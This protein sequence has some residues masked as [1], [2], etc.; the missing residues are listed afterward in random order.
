MKNKK[1]ISSI[2]ATPLLIILAIVA[3]VIIYPYI[4]TLISQELI[5]PKF[6]TG[7]PSSQIGTSC[8]NG[9]KETGEECD[10]M[11]LGEV[12]NCVDLEFVSGYLSCLQDCTFN[13]DECS[14]QAELSTY[15]CKSTYATPSHAPIRSGSCN[16]N[17]CYSGYSYMY[18]DYWTFAPNVSE[19]CS[20]VY[21]SACSLTPSCNESWST[22]LGCSFEEVGCTFPTTAVCGNSNCEAP[23][24]T[25]IN[26]PADCNLTSAIYTNYETI[27]HN[28]IA[29]TYKTH[30][31]A[32]YN[33]TTPTPLVIALHGGG[34][35]GDT[36]EKQLDMNAKAEEECFIALYP[37][38]SSQTAPTHQHWNAGPRITDW[39]SYIQNINDTDFISTLIEKMKTDYS[40]D[41]NKVYVTGVS[42]GAMMAYRLACEI[43]N[44][45]T[46]IA[47]IAGGILN[48]TCTPSEPVSIIHFHG[49]D[50]KMYPFD[51]GVSCAV[52]DNFKSVPNTI[53][54]W[55]AI[56]HCQNQPIITYRLGEASC[57][58]YN[59]CDS[60]T[61]IT[62]CTI[63][64]GGH[65]IP[66][67]YVFP[68]EKFSGVG[69]VTEDINAMDEMWAFFENNS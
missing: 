22:Q 50:D 53:Q 60:S 34:G 56:D 44:K 59:G 42:N 29:R 33:P 67:G 64:N 65:T 9:I 1:G 54:D 52:P 23:Q 41:E 57:E 5:F 19:L 12:T 7:N 43:S 27:I 48:I 36:I 40:I 68:I 61:E 26:C 28:T 45:I 31:P 69:K 2:I 21:T 20:I 3:I 63:E 25:N 58:T 47:P 13:T 14:N 6:E 17:N 4:K 46:A 55:I 38:G 30:I 15:T 8:G 11:D 35:N 16:P 49:L 32:C 24:E 10:K 39:Y 66:G 62:L 18:C 37:D 51:G